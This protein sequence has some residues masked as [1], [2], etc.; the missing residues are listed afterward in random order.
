MITRSS[1]REVRK[2]VPTFFCS[3]I[4]RGTLP[5]KKG[6]RA[7]LGDLVMRPMQFERGPA[8]GKRSSLGCLPL[9]SV[10]DP[11]SRRF[12]LESSNWLRS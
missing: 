8:M 10:T 12:Q 2:R 6:K 4:S 9:P 1:S 11:E 5:P 3:L 7:L